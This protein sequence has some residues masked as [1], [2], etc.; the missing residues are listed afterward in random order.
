MK[1]KLIAVFVASLVCLAYAAIAEDQI[2]TLRKGIPLNNENIKPEKLV[3]SSNTDIRQVRAYPMQPPLI[4]H[5]IEGY[6]VD[7]YA[8]KC[9]SCHARTRIGESQAPMISVTHFQDRDG[10]FLADVSPRRYFCNQCHVT[11]VEREPLLKNEF[12]SV[13]DLLSK[14][15]VQ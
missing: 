9:L 15:E 8:N 4:P 10:N 12:Q 3:D 13:D 6:Q 1:N 2:A 11:Q 7:K 14:K 5:K